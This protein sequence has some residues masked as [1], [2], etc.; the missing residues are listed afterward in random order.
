MLSSQ[1]TAEIS[2][3]DRTVKIRNDDDLFILFKTV[4]QNKVC[5]SFDL[6]FIEIRCELR[7]T[8][9]SFLCNQVSMDISVYHP[10]PFW[11]G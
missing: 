2:G 9:C 8:I 3:R 7:Q 6:S 10:V 1:P 5:V 4:E 11:F